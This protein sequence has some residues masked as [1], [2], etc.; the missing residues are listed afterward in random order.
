M[1]YRMPLGTPLMLA[2]YSMHLSAHKYVDPPKFWPDRYMP[3]S[4]PD[5]GKHSGQKCV[6]SGLDISAA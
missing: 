5:N 2:P 6:T 1:G 3:E 4:M